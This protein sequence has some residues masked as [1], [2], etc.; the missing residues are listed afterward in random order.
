MIAVLH[1]HQSRRSSFRSCS[2]T[3]AR[4]FS[5]DGSN[6]GANVAGGVELMAGSEWRVCLGA[7]QAI[8]SLAR[9]RN[10]KKYF[11]VAEY[12]TALQDRVEP[13]FRTRGFASGIWPAGILKVEQ[14][15]A[16]FQL[17]EDQLGDFAQRFEDALAGYRDGFR[18]RFAFDLQLLCQLCHGKNS[19]EVALVELQHVGDGF[20][21]EL[22]F[23][24]VLAQVVQS[25]QVRVQPLFLRIRHEN[26]AIGAFQD[27]LAAGF[28][29]DLSRHGVKMNSRL[30]SAHSAEIDG[31]KIEE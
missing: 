4:R 19:R 1:S 27:Q 12:D 20:E 11:G 30:E 31:K 28:V 17:G 26:N 25:F 24:Q 2:F 23:L 15:S 3:S 8:I 10:R 29:K 13:F 22:V 21:V 7:R 9:R 5:A 14:L 18:D 16:F 6:G